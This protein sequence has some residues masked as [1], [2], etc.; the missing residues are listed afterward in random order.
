MINLY[1]YIYITQLT[2]NRLARK[3]ITIQVTN[4]FYV[5]TY[6]QQHVA[7]LYFRQI[8]VIN[9]RWTYFC[10]IDKVTNIKSNLTSNIFSFLTQHNNSGLLHHLLVQYLTTFYSQ[11]RIKLCFFI[12]QYSTEFTSLI[13]QSTNM[14][15]YIFHINTRTITIGHIRTDNDFELSLICS[16]FSRLRIIT[17]KLWFTS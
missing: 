8:D 4:Y 5:Q 11:Q 1:I 15:D 7:R 2:L 17:F 10:H 9:T 16:R 12:A 3:K 13:S 14:H 6:F